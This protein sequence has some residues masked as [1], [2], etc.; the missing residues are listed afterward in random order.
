MFVGDNLQCDVAAPLACGM[1]A[2]LVRPQ[3]LRRG[4]ALPDAALLI[5]H[6]RDL[7]ALLNSLTP[8]Q[9]RDGA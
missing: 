2:A 5:E 7:T 6:V 9:K 3:G 1:R 8:D 4:E